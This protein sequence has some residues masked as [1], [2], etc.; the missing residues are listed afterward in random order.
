M[1]RAS[2]SPNAMTDWYPDRPRN[3]TFA[4]DDETEHAGSTR[5]QRHANADLARSLTSP[6][7]PQRRSV[8]ADCGHD[9]REHAE[10]AKQPCSDELGREKPQRS[11]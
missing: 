2:I 4:A 1:A 9:E 6:R 10:R 7:T 11:R 3:A 5:T 8:D